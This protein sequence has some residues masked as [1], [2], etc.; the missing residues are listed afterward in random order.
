MIVSF[1]ATLS[2]SLPGEGG[3][4]ILEK[5]NEYVSQH[6]IE[7]FSVCVNVHVSRTISDLKGNVWSV[8]NNDGVDTYSSSF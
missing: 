8:I 2:L 6:T 7:N 3:A 1:S 4:G 5:K